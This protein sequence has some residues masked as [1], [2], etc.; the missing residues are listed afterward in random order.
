MQYDWKP[1]CCIVRHNCIEAHKKERRNKEGHKQQ[2]R[3]KI[4]QKWKPMDTTGEQMH[5][6]Q[7]MQEEGWNTTKKK[8]ATKHNHS[9]EEMGRY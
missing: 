8:S 3:N 5:K 9:N 4:K 2:M 7:N 6:N 1:T